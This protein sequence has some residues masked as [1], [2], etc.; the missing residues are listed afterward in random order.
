MSE[1]RRSVVTITSVVGER[2]GVV[3]DT[4]VTGSEGAVDTSIHGGSSRCP[5]P[6]HYRIIG[7]RP[8]VTSVYVPSQEVWVSNADRT[9]PTN[10]WSLSQ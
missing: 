7:V 5:R 2:R 1:S 9:V 3:A 8:D 6:L 4:S 10:D